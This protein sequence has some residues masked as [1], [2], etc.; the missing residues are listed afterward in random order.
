MKKNDYKW[1]WNVFP[2]DIKVFTVFDYKNTWEREKFVRNSF[3]FLNV[4]C[5]NPSDA[6]SES[7]RNWEPLCLSWFE[8]PCSLWTFIVIVIIIIIII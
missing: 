1:N 5:L 2:L 8:T 7:L 3:F 6:K 4:A